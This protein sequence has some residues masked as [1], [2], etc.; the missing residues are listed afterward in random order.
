MTRPSSIHS[1]HRLH[2][3]RRVATVSPLIVV[4]E[5]ICGILGEKPANLIRRTRASPPQGDTPVE[6]QAGDHG[7]PPGNARATPPAKRLKPESRMAVG[8]EDVPLSHRCARAR[9]VRADKGHHVRV[10]KSGLSCSIGEQIGS[11]GRHLGG[12]VTM[13]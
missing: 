4:S 1:L 9:Q 2:A 10:R 13:P 8:L 12:T 3:L 11:N 6:S 5:P 7:W